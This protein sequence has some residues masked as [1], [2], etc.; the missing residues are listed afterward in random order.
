MSD[1]TLNE[2]CPNCVTPW[3]CNGP[4]I[5]AHDLVARL[6]SAEFSTLD[7]V[8]AYAADRLELLEGILRAWVDAY[9]WQ[10]VDRE[11][12]CYV[13]AKAALGMED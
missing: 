12:D 13:K 11:H 2:M 10:D 1:P 8:S 6:R 4:H 3:K 7:E 5:P 9:N